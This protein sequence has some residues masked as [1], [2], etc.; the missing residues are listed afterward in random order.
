[1]RY[2]AIGSAP[3]AAVTAADAAQ[4]ARALIAS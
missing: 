3:G 2:D 4:A 1:V